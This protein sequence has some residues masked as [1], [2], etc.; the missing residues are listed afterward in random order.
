MSDY[1]QALRAVVEGLPA[2]FPVSLPRE[3]VLDLLGAATD[4]DLSVADAAAVLGRAP[5]TVRDWCR[6]GDI[7]GAYLFR[8]EYRIPRQRLE[9]FRQR[10]SEPTTAQDAGPAAPTDL[11]AWRHHAKKAS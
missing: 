7:P 4:R 9:E 10:E 6:R 8:K 2:G 11:G 5:S 1:R 3:T